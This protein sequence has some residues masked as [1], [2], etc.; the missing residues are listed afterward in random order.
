MENIFESRE[1]IEESWELENA[2]CLPSWRV[3]RAYWRE[4]RKHVRS[5]EKLL[6]R[7]KNETI[8]EDCRVVIRSDFCLPSWRVRRAD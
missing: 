2:C 8:G 3:G 4:F 6:E 7:E 5:Q 1:Q